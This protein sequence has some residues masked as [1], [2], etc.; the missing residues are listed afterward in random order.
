MSREIMLLLS[1]DPST[2]QQLVVTIPTKKHA[3]C[4]LH[5]AKTPHSRSKENNFRISR[6][7]P[8]AEPDMVW[9]MG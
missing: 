3:L 7:L 1:T 9:V 4:V 5:K 2:L 8:I 6:L